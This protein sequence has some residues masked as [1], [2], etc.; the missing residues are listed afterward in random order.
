MPPASS[1]SVVTWKQSQYI[2]DPEQPVG[3]Q[4]SSVEEGKKSLP[5]DQVLGPKDGLA[6]DSTPEVGMDLDPTDTHHIYDADQ[7]EGVIM[8]KDVMIGLKVGSAWAFRANAVEWIEDGGKGNY[9]YR[10]GSHPVR[11]WHSAYTVVK[12]AIDGTHLD[13]TNGGGRWVRSGLNSIGPG[14]ISLVATQAE[15]AQAIKNAP[16]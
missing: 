13:N 2:W 5:K 12:V 14:H 3:E 4:F 8:S 11:T 15:I 9:Q 7:P 16:K 10:E 1:L 6:N